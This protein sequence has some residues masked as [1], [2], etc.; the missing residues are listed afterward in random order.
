MK[1]SLKFD[2]FSFGFGEGLRLVGGGR[3]V[4]PKEVCEEEAVSELNVSG[5]ENVD[6]VVR[7]V[8]EGSGVSAVGLSRGIFS[9]LLLGLT[10]PVTPL[11]M[12]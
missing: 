8:V 10:R 5:R 9:S 4:S 2:F 12:T 7:E 1:V 3:S 11:V 6:S